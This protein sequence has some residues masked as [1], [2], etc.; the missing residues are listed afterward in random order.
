MYAKA[1]RYLRAGALGDLPHLSHTE[2]KPFLVAEREGS[3]GE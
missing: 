3:R 2:V 1:W